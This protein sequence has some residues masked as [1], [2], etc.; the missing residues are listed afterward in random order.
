MNDDA[1]LIFIYIYI[2]RV[3]Q[4]C[5]S[6]AYIQLTP[7]T[8]TNF[9]D[10]ALLVSRGCGSSLTVGFGIGLSVGLLLL[11]G[12]ELARS[13]GGELPESVEAVTTDSR[14]RENLTSRSSIQ[15]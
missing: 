9:P 10:A 3:F 1:L 15:S 2:E 7:T 6:L 4:Y 8:P 12:T 13:P 5:L 14:N 11:A